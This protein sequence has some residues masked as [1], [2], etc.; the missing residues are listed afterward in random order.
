M[1]AR[2]TRFIAFATIAIL[3]A[4]CAR[5]PI[6]NRVPAG[7]ALPPPDP[8][9]TYRQASEYRLGAQDLLEIS[10]FR[11]PDLSRTVRVNSNGEISLPLIGSVHAGGL[12]IGELE[13]EL[14]SR[15]ADGFI[16]NPQ[17]TVF[18]KESA[19]Q[20]VTVEG[21]IEKPGVYPLTGATTLL[22]TIAMAGDLAPLADLDGVVLFRYI[23]GVKMAAVYDMR[24]LRAG[25]VEDPAIHGGDLVVV[26]QSG[27]KTALRYFIESIPALGLFVALDRSSN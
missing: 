1:L 10:V 2:T 27:S 18:V 16:K 11:V 19:S 17:V 8:S 24:A 6:A 22:Q 23:D 12:S 26:E 25:Q 14:A 9:V 20:R 15:Y 7:T 21:A 4:G 13:A 3:L 5:M